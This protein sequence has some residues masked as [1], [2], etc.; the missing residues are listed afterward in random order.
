[1]TNE[2]KL[3]EVFGANPLEE[4]AGCNA[5]LADCCID[6]HHVCSECEFSFDNWLKGEYHYLGKETKV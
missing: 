4:F 2:E 3:I 6:W 1:M 5:C